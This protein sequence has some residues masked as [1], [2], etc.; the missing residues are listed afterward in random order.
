M[1]IMW[2][3]LLIQLL[4]TIN[5]C[6]F[7]EERTTYEFQDGHLHH[8]L[9]EVRWL[10]LDYLHGDNLVRLHVLTLNDLTERSL[11][12]DIQDQVPEH[13]TDNRCSEIKN[14]LAD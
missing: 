9:V 4:Y 7:I 14:R 13:A 11:A 2:V 12:Q 1:L 3:T 8:T 10:V 5:S 6:A